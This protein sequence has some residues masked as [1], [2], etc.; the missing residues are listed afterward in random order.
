MRRVLMLSFAMVLFTMTTLALPKE[1]EGHKFVDAATL[2]IINKAH[3]DGLPLSRVDISKFG[4]PEFA[5]EYLS[6][7]TGV[8]VVFKTNSREISAKWFTKKG[9]NDVTTS[10]FFQHGLDLY[11]R[12]GG[13]WVFA[14]VGRPKSYGEYHERMIVS[15]MAEGEKECLLY[16][17]MYSKLTSL[18]IGVEKGATIEAIPSPFKHKILFVGSSLTHGSAASRPGLAYVARMGRLLNAETPNIGVGGKC[19]LDDY[20]INIVC[21]T[22][23]DAYIFDTFSNPTGQQVEERLYNFVKRIV[24]AHPDK[25]M[26]FLQTLKYDKTRFDLDYR[27]F[28]E[29]QRGAAVKGMAKICKEFK[30]VYFVDPALYVGEDGEGTSDGIHLNDLGTQRTLD[31]VMPKVRKILKRYGIK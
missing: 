21:A 23:A 14:G 28:S 17:P 9:K 13:K 25:P 29:G 8:A 20:F 2:T 16:F 5:K 18:E 11:I 6:H 3:N 26:I 31:V 12:E 30:N 24:E 1:L 27:K 22:E 7:S 4:I 19:K 15:N 10:G